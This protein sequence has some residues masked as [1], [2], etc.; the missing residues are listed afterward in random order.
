KGHPS[1]P[2]SNCHCTKPTAVTSI[3]STAIAKGSIGSTVMSYTSRKFTIVLKFIS[4]YP[5]SCMLRF[6]K[7][8]KFH[9]LHR[10]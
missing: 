9:S 4:Y 8:C 10:L 6:T 2:I 1:L 5:T 7:P 3:F